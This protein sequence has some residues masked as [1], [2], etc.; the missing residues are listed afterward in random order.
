MVGTWVV[1][2]LC[3]AQGEHRRYL[4]FFGISGLKNAEM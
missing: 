2:R 4:G 1:A 3:A